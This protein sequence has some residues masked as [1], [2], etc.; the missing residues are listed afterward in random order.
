MRVLGHIHTF[1]E[2]AVIDRSL[3]ALLDQTY[4]VGEILLVDNASTDDTLN[5][6]FPDQVKVISFRENSLTSAPIITAMQYAKEHGYDWVWLL[7]GDS[8]PRA[9]ALAK[10]MDLYSSFD[11]ELQESV[12]LLAA[13]PVDITTQRSDHGFMVTR[14][15]LK[16]VFP[17]PDQVAYECDATI[18]SGSVYK[19]TAVEKVGLPRADYAMD[20]A[21]I[22]Y[23]YRGRRLGYR[24]FVHQGSILDHNLS[25]PSV[26]SRSLRFGPVTLKLIEV[27]PFRCYYVVRNV[28]YFWFYDYHDRNVFTYAY[29]IL[30][31]AKFVASFVLRPATHWRQI[32]ACARGLWDGLFN[33]MDSRYA[34]S[35]RR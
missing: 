12:W 19:L 26:T 2:A 32:A 14:R 9:D 24:A 11:A 16:Q 34:I 3:R 13:L 29:C 33:R 5:R 31:I 23:G 4:P 10:L 7:D 6:P 20:I 35:P 18:W 15:G 22:E 30:K 17:G 27:Q 21:E 8:A 1:N 25:G 28:V